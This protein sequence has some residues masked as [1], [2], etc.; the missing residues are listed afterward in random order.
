MKS[1]LG[2]SRF[3][4]C[5]ELAPALTRVFR[6]QVL[7]VSRIV[8]S[9]A[10]IVL[11]FMVDVILCRGSTRD[12]QVDTVHLANVFALCCMKLRFILEVDQFD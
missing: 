9:M 6:I 10:F 12:D 8:G 3:M 2:V 4:F 1:R 5:R 7:V 11:L